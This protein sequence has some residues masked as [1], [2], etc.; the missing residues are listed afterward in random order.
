[1]GVDES[2]N[3]LMAEVSWHVG[4]AASSV[5]VSMISVS[6]L[7]SHDNVV[8]LLQVLDN[9]F[10]NLPDVRLFDIN[11]VP[12][13]SREIHDAEVGSLRSAQLDVENL[14]GKIPTGLLF[15]SPDAQFQGYLCSSQ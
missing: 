7:Y 5:S 6:G 10:L 9:H 4:H 3:V 13:L 11:R 2:R 14:G 15:S 1:M 8:W 12:K